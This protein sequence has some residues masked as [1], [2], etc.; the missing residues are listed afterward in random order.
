[1]IGSHILNLAHK[2]TIYD[3][4]V[5]LKEPGSEDDNLDVLHETAIKLNIIRPILRPKIN[6]SLTNALSEHC[7]G[8]LNDVMATFVPVKHSG[9]KK[10]GGAKALE[11]EGKMDW[12]KKFMPAKVVMRPSERIALRAFRDLVPRMFW[13]LK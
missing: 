11:V 1:M 13:V 10:A 5:A 4:K 7:V 3:S 2:N 12:L 6:E 9:G 8:A